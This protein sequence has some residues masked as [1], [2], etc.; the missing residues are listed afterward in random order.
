M[1]NC[2]TSVRTFHF[3]TIDTQYNISLFHSHIFEFSIIQFYDF[4]TIINIIMISYRL[5]LSDSSLAPKTSSLPI[6]AVTTLVFPAAFFSTIGTVFSF[7]FLI[8]VTVS[9]ITGTV[10]SYLFLQF[11]NSIYM[12]PS[13][14]IITSFSFSPASSAEPSS[15]T[16]V[17]STPFT[18]FRFCFSAS[19][20]STSLI[21]TPISAL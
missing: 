18:S 5:N 10:F 9:F 11:R 3:F 12:F 15:I 1:V 21:F 8:Y 4:Y 2:L 7:P 16:L 17:I 14:L 19:S 13:N 6:P 20:D